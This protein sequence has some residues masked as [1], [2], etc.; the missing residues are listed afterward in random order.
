MKVNERV[1][2]GNNGFPLIISAII[3]PTLQTSTKVN[4][5]GR[6]KTIY[7]ISL[8]SHISKVLSASDKLAASIR[9]FSSSHESIRPFKPNCTVNKRI[10]EATKFDDARTGISS[11]TYSSPLQVTTFDIN[12]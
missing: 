7:R 5:C 1:F 8:T 10:N 3:H 4:I 12:Y 6:S 9:Q 11:N 2:P